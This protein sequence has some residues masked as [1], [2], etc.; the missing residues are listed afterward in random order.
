MWVRIAGILL[1]N[2]V[3]SIIT[4]MCITI[5]MGFEARNIEMSYEAADLLPK[6][7]TAYLNYLEFRSTFGKEENVMV[8][9]LQ[10]SNFYQINKINDWLKLGRDIN[11][12]EGVT[13]FISITHALNINKNSQE[14]KFDI[15]TN[16]K[17]SVSSQ[18]ELDSLAKIAE[19]LPFYDGT[20]VNKKNH[21]YSAMI[22]LSPEV[23]NSPK[24]V[25]LVNDILDLTKTFSSTHN[26]H[27]HYSGMPYIRVLNAENVKSEMFLFIV[28]SLLITAIILY[29]FFRSWRI[30]GFCVSIIGLGVIWAIGFMAIFH[31]K[32]TLLTAMLPPLIIVIGIP[33]CVYMVNKYHSEY[34]HH[35]NK[36]MAL[37]RMIYKVGTASLMSNLTTAAGFATFI[38]TSSRILVE[39]GLIS[40]VSIASV[41]VI[42]L[43]LIPAVFSFLPAPEPKQTRHLHN[44]II[45]R[46]IEKIIFMVVHKK[47]VIFSITAILMIISSIGISKMKTTG[48][49]VDDLKESDPIRKDL[50]F[51]EKNFG[52]LMPLEISI[53][54][55]K[56]RQ[57]LELNNLQKVQ[58][59]DAELSQDTVLSNSLSILS[60]IKFINQAYYNGKVNYYKLPTAFNKNFIMRYT[61]NS[62]DTNKNNI[63][64]GFVDSSMQT[65]RLS[66][67]VHDIG[68][69][70]MEAKEDSIIKAVNKYFPKDKYNTNITG[71]SIIFFKG[72][73]YLISNLFT[74]LALAILLI[75]CFMAWVFRSK[76]MVLIALIPNIIPQIITAAIMGYAGIPI[77][78]STILVFSVAFG[79]SV[80]N[81]IHYLAKYKQEL[82]LCN[83]R[84]YSSVILSLKEVG[85]SM[86]YTSIILF[87]GFSIFCL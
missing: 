24:R 65:L 38:I 40:F 46:I 73:K 66:Y 81:T 21:S 27:L 43:V 1:R 60:A 75:T 71:S 79:I 74:S 63:A 9:A 35:H 13:S 22:T 42:C 2:R 84:I 12:L 8:F 55:K 37:Q 85:Q 30:V 23:M 45:G 29:L 67:R 5:Y 77:K 57:V 16:F 3:A 34:V 17:D 80:D 72:N 15:S 58:K 50:T 83:W 44:P 86:I 33:N 51:F 4:I 78:A 56:P 48:Y 52:G 28:L 87:F 68:T 41:F 47:S 36:I 25:K 18:S 19:S 20:L 62:L 53:D 49:M 70:R 7:D 61:A 54:F 26:L 76:R 14:Q 59:L 11:D 82:Q 6:T 69:K 31:T 32:I 39:F 64:K 10:D